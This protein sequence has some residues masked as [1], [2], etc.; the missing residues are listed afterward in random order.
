MKEIVLEILLQMLLIIIA[1]RPVKH[2]QLEYK[3]LTS[4]LLFWYS[5]DGEHK[6]KYL[7]LNQKPDLEAMYKRQRLF[8]IY[9]LGLL[10]LIAY[11]FYLIKI[12][13]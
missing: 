12:F 1:Y 11:L 7:T 2:A 4:E 6:R 13:I 3:R 5:T 9:L 8:I 10:L